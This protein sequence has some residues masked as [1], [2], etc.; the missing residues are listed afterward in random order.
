MAL[1]IYIL[2]SF[3]LTASGPLEVSGFCVIVFLAYVKVYKAC[4]F[5][6]YKFSSFL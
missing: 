5:L 1:Q 3:H 2:G 4:P 6:T